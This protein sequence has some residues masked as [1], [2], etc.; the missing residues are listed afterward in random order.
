MRH[1]VSGRKLGRTASHRKATLSALSVALIT[2][3][4][5]RTTVAKAK[6]TRMVVEKLITRAKNAVA[7]EA[8]AT[9]KDVHARRESFSYLHDRKAVS[10]LFNDIAP[11]VAARPGGYTRVV[12]LGQRQ[13]DGAELA[14]LELV[15]YNLAQEAAAQKQASKASKPRRKRGAPKSTKGESPA[16]ETVVVPESAPSAESK[17][18]SATGASKGDKTKKEDK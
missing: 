12:K 17:D 18:A 16:K 5:I 1:Q 13:G 8:G 4:K 3:K 10:T 15:D 6:E 2:H 7:R 9:Q 14:V 11:K